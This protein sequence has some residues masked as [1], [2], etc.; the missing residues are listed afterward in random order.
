MSY[1]L[2]FKV[3][4]DS[5]FYK[6]Y[7]ASKDEKEKFRQLAVAFTAKHGIDGDIYVSKV[8]AVKPPHGKHRAFADQT[9]VKPDKEGFYWF[10]KK[11][12]I[13]QMWDAEVVPHVNWEHINKMDFWWWGHIQCGSYSLWDRDGEI[14][15][16]LE[17]RAQKEIAPADFMEPMKMSE[18]YAIIE[19]YEECPKE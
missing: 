9:K 4:H 14:Y 17:D 12:P 3:K 6:Q 15:G 5:D 7:F 10:K 2:A 1:Q 16:Y 18:Y 11:S 19:S 8:L 13:R